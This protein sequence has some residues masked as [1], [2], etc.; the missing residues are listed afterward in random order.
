[1]KQLIAGKPY[2]Y[3]QLPFWSALAALLYGLLR[4]QSPPDLFYQSDKW[5]HLMAF[6]VLAICAHIA[7]RVLPTGLLWG[8]LLLTAPGLEL[9]QHL[10]QPYRTFSALDALA[11][12]SGVLLGG[13][14]WWLYTRR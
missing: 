2:L 8:V 4:P 10:V 13:A 11:N 3:R 9:L 7:F 5:L 6:A 12:L 1:M 14:A